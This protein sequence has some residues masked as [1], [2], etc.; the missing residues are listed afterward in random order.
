MKIDMKQNMR[1]TGA[2][3]SAILLYYLIHEGAHMIYAIKLGVFRQLQ[4]TGLGVQVVTNRE[5]MSVSQ[6]A[7]FC[8]LGAVTT[9]L[10]GW[11]LVLM[12]A[13]IM[14]RKS[15]FLRAVSFY[16]TLILLL[17]DPLYLSVIYPYVGGGDM[18][19]IKL[20]IPEIPARILFG[21]IFMVHLVVIVKYIYPAYRERF[22]TP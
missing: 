9:F 17:N 10:T 4:F 5:L 21:A 13:R 11:I 3:V 15:L 7:V 1:K 16:T 8:V 14:E 20:M 22:L 2:L 18:N 19:G 12:T 6:T